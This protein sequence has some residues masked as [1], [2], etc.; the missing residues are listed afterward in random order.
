[1]PHATDGDLEEGSSSNTRWK[2]FSM[3]TMDMLIPQRHSESAKRQGCCSG[4]LAELRQQLASPLDL[5][6]AQR[7]R[8][9]E[10]TRRLA[11][12]RGVGGEYG[13]VDL[14]ESVM[15]VLMDDH[16]EEMAVA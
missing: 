14:S 6:N 3:E 7:Q 15:S 2:G 10:L 8:L 9:V 12:V 16:A 11:R 4:D 1:M 13:R 5:S